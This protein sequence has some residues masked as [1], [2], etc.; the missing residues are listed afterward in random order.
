MNTIKINTGFRNPNLVNYFMTF[1][2][3]FSWTATDGTGL[4]THTTEKKATGDRSLKITNSQYI[5]LDLT[6]SAIGKNTGFTL[7]ESKQIAFSFSLYNPTQSTE[8]KE[9]NLTFNLFK[10]GSPF[11]TF[12]VHSDEFDKWVNYGQLLNLDAGVYTVTI[13]QKKDLTSL[14]NSVYIYIDNVYFAE[15]KEL[16]GLP[17]SY[18]EPKDLTSYGG[19]W[20]Y[21]IDSLANPSINIGTTFTQI[22]IDTLG[23][24]ITSYLPL[25]VTSLFSGNKITPNTLGADYDGRLDIKVL[26]KA[27]SPNLIEVIIDISGGTA[28]TNK[29]YTGYIQTGGVIPYDQTLPLDF[30]SLST[31]LANGGKIYART[32]TG[33]V[34]IG[35]RKIK[36][37]RKSR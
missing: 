32:D 34:T 2:D 16:I 14:L 10:D 19:G 15:D 27:G 4:G 25:G 29:V 24:N 1:N 21:Y 28:G 8:Q 35:D 11:T 9:Q 30:F 13:T 33:S 18:V 12:D 22:T 17:T 31:F 37:S 26:T 5:E 7:T 3:S 23:A 36:I 20:A 6:I